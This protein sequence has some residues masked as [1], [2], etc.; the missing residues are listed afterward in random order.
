MPSRK[1]SFYFDIDTE[2]SNN[3]EG[4]HSHATCSWCNGFQ[5]EAEESSGAELED[6]ADELEDHQRNTLRLVEIVRFALLDLREALYEMLVTPG[7]IMMAMVWS[8]YTVSVLVIANGFLPYMLLY[9]L[10]FILILYAETLEQRRM[11][12]QL[13]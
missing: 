12:M 9:S 2:R 10:L 4:L 3:N 11:R 8:G 1:L 6:T 5:D 13:Q 7:R